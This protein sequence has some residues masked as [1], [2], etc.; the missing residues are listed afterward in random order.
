M[1]Q[2]TVFGTAETETYIELR[3]ADGRVLYF[4]VT[5]D[6]VMHSITAEDYEKGT[7]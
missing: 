5:P 1:S 2:D 4:R 3:K 6:G 7:A